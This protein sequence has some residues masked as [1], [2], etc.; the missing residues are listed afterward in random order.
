MQNEVIQKLSQQKEHEKKM[1]E[2][3]PVD[4]L[5]NEWLSD[6]KE[7]L[8][9]QAYLLE[10]LLPTLMPGVE[11]MLMEV[12]KR[13]LLGPIKKKTFDPIN[14]L[15]EYLM[16]NNP[17][18]QKDLPET[19][20]LKAMKNV[21]KTMKTKIPNTP[22]NRVFKIKREVKDNRE[23]RENIERIKTHVGRMR[24][25][26]LT[27]QFQEWILDTDRKIPLPVIEN[28]IHAFLDT[29]AGCKTESLYQPMEFIGSMKDKLDE[30]HFIEVIFPCIKELTS[31]MFTDFLRHL[32]QCSGDFYDIL[33]H[34]KWRQKFLKL[35][36]AC[37]VG[38]LGFLDR[39]RTLT[40][41]ENF[42]DK[43]PKM[44]RRLFFNPKFWPFIEFEEV[45]PAE[46]WGDM[47]DEK[48]PFERYDRLSQIEWKKSTHGIAKKL[49][50]DEMDLIGEEEHERKV[51]SWSASTIA[52]ED[53]FSDFHEAMEEE[54]GEPSGKKSFKKLHVLPEE[55]PSESQIETQISHE[56]KQEELSTEQGEPSTEQG[57][58]STEQGEPSTEQGEPSTEKRKTSI[59]EEEPPKEQEK[60]VKSSSSKGSAEEQ[61]ST[62]EEQDLK[63]EVKKSSERKSE[64][65]QRSSEIGL[66]EPG[67]EPREPSEPGA[68][69]G[70]LSASATEGKESSIPE[71]ST[72]PQRKSTLESPKDFPQGEEDEI[73]LKSS[74]DLLQESGEKDSNCEPQ[75]QLI[76]G[77]PWSG[78]LLTSDLSITYMKYGE[79]M[80]A[81]LVSDD[82]RFLALRPIILNLKR[83]EKSRIRSAF[84]QR[85]L[86]LPQF[87]QLLD[88]FVGDGIPLDIM[89]KFTVFF[90]KNYMETEDDKINNLE[91]IYKE[92]IE[93]RRKLL[94]DALFQKWDNEGSGFLELQKIDNLLFTYKEGMERASMNKAKLHII[95]P[96]PHPGKEV[97]LTIDHF[98]NY[99]EL[100]VAELTGNE[101]EV[102]DNVVEF[103]MMSLKPTHLEQLRNT[104]RH[105]WLYQI[106]RAAETSRVCLEP[107][108]T[109]VF[110]A[111]TEDAE[112]HGYSKRISAHISLLEENEKMPER[113]STILRIVACTAADVP[114]VL[115]Q[116]LYRDMKGISFT[117]VDQGEPIH[118]PEVDKHGNI[119]FWN[120]SCEPTKQKG[121]FLALP[122]EDAYKR[123]FG[124]LGID[125]LRNFPRRTIFSAHEISFYQGVANA[126]S[127]A[128]HYIHSQEHILHV[129]ATAANWL[130]IVT[131]S[132]KN[133][134][135]FLVEPGP[136]YE[137]DYGLQKMM[138]LDNKKHVEI[139]FQS[140]VIYRKKSLF[141]DFLFKSA[142]TSQVLFTYALGTYHIT[143]P[144]RDRKGMAMGVI[145]FSTGQKKMLSNQEY[146][147]LQKML[148]T[149]QTACHEILGESTGEIKKQQIL[150]T[151]YK[152][153]VQK[154][155]ILFFRIMLKEIQE[156][157]H[158]LDPQAFKDLKFH[159]ENFLS[160][161]FDSS[162]FEKNEKPPALAHDI[163][164][165]ILLIFNPEWDGAEIL[166]DW[167]QCRQLITNDMI[168]RL[169]TFDPTSEY[170][171]VHPD[172]I[173][174]YIKRH[175]RKVIW[176]EGSVALEYMYH[177]VL[178][179][180]FLI[181]MNLKLKEKYVPPLPTGKRTHKKKT[182]HKA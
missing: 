182:T 134:T 75:T 163:L 111:L 27:L 148:K 53:D 57:E 4:D 151:E 126:F 81:L 165:A 64:T 137:S 180:L 92:T 170:V 10:K 157:I 140:S 22:D 15:G 23:R 88:T 130:R 65:E 161:I 29:P 102:F 12:E 101:D 45:E 82:P 103:L 70:E 20:Y 63:T 89:K 162:T 21:T 50:Q 6:D 133:I 121:S 32:Y 78:D 160:L 43:N 171:K 41:L 135:T 129:I 77:K 138:Y 28:A 71:E 116:V 168:K 68:E 96:K 179:C 33:K 120:T 62:T 146:R 85:Y 86:N 110:K 91:K 13:K 56:A 19:G 73:L 34:D 156:R 24:K 119:H 174:K 115:N 67:A 104:A 44:V 48:S 35:F 30:E 142:D 178:V 9:T 55:L 106:Q 79:N 54:K 123:T 173:A 72:E 1:A 7:T 139:V 51:V 60:S 117:V 74:E 167:D 97:R 181:E 42:Y 105:K 144:L 107:V 47:D 141:R 152:G 124:V 172:T 98:R 94:L 149:V 69:P 131:P 143:V 118:V 26:A 166:E 31:D 5:A 83:Q 87:V 11:K 122:L 150:E 36:F 112:A 80:R 145:D 16:R 66:Q 61:R 25:E 127:I 14:Y 100:V 93:Q 125:T 114:F 175:P 154:A 176:I 58:P 3:F 59:P 177:W 18:F 46:F 128:Y 2:K 136:D 164:K 39:E 132:I 155:G 90:K 17:N 169:C 95:L 8:D 52:Y 37:D 113:G 147:D 159:S 108:Y 40:L 153:E 76:D 38:K 84:S 109:E 99:I 49:P 158:E